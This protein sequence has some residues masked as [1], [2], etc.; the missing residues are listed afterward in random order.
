[1]IFTGTIYT[2]SSPG[3]TVL[4]PTFLFDASAAIFL[5]K[6]FLASMDLSLQAMSQSG[7]RTCLAFTSN[8]DES[9][10][11]KH[12]ECFSN[13]R[14][15]RCEGSYKKAISFDKIPA[16]ISSTIS[17]ALE[18]LDTRS[19]IPSSDLCSGLRSIFFSEPSV[20]QLKRHSTEGTHGILFIAFVNSGW[21][22]ALFL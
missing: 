20:A 16:Q 9:E 5:T 6:T 1:M 13:P 12:A 14:G 4:I 19:I 7:I 15:R 17:P 8:D 22:V 11:R 2:R 18:N 21:F 3:G 10:S